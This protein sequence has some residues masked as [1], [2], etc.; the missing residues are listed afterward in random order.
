MDHL[1]WRLVVRF[2]LKRR[3]CRAE[4]FESTETE[5]STCQVEHSVEDVRLERYFHEDIAQECEH[6]AEK[7]HKGNDTLRR[8]IIVDA[9]EHIEPEFFHFEP[10]CTLTIS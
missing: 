1:E 4:F 10:R 6:A 9:F 8:D 5:S 3:C 7:G 2:G